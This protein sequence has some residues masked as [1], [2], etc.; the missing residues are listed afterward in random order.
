MFQPGPSERFTFAITM[1]RRAPAAQLVISCMYNRPWALVAVNV[2]T[3]VMLAPIQAAI[4]E[5]SLSTGIYR[6]FIWPLVTKSAIVSTISVCGVIGYAATTAGR[7]C[8]TAFAIALF[9]VAISFMPTPPLPR[10]VF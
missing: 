8:L 5:C 7:A 2:R 1:G 3:P 4:A 6:L 9:P 10:R